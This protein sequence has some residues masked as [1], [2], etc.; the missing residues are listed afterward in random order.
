LAACMYS[1]AI[2]S[3]LS[4]ARSGVSAWRANSKQ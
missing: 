4:L 2:L 1:R 3:S